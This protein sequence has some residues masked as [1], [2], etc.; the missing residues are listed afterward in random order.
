M[1]T[2]TE[3][4]RERMLDASFLVGIAIKVLNALGDLLIG[5]PLLFVRPDQLSA[6]A[7]WL[8]RDELAHDPD[9]LLA[10]LVVG[11]ASNLSASSLSYAAVYLLVHAVVKIAILIALARGSRR[12]YPWIIGALL[13]LFVYQMVDF[14]FTHSLTMLVLS[15]LDGIVIWLTYRE[16]R[17][18]RVLRD[19]LHRYW[20]RF[21]SSRLFA[22][23]ASSSR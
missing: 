5:I 15:L 8:T 23:S 7:Q 22:P 20:P 10:N 1:R 12:W 6:L 17:H 21:A 11:A 9:D 3:L 16:W 18:H 19:V 2:D 13:A 14:A 4:G